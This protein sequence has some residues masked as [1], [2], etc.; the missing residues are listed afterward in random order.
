MS[1]SNTLFLAFSP[2]VSFYISLSPSLLSL[3]L[4]LPFSSSFLPN[5]H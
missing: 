2:S 1:L 4:F 5:W 3:T